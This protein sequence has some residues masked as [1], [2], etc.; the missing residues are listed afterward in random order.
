MRTTVTTPSLYYRGTQRASIR[1]AQKTLSFTPSLP[2]A[3]IWSARPGNIWLGMSPRFLKTSTV[4]KVQLNTKKQLTL[5][6]YSHVALSDILTALKYEEGGISCKEVRKIYQYLHNRIIGKAK[7]GDFSYRLYDEEGEE[8]DDYE[9]PLSL[10]RPH[11]IISWYG[12]DQWE[13]EPTLETASCLWADTFVFA[14]SPAV[15]RAAKAQGYDSIAY[16]DVFAGGEYASA[17]LLGCPVWDLSG[18]EE[19]TEDKGVPVHWTVRPLDMKIIKLLESVPT[20]QIVQ[21]KD[22]CNG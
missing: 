4:H 12:F 19:D 7:G 22:L 21:T 20:E 6:E 15:Q 13:D 17:D 3:V 2:V 8:V 10:R 16:V 1:G 9:V 11:T 18:V 14:D 5:P